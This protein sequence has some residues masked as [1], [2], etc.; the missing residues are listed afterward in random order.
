MLFYQYDKDMIK[1]QETVNGNDVEFNI[2]F[3]NGTPDTID[4]MKQV[5]KMF[6]ENDV[7]TDVLFYTHVDHEF[8]VIV[9]R[10]YYVDFVLALMKFR[11]L[12]R[13]EWTA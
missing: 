8:R 2:Q 9:R 7:H 10:D 3:I 12:K 11:L 4:A 1:I 6:E 13:V 5:Q